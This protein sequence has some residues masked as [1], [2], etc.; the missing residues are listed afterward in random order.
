MTEE[1]NEEYDSITQ[2]DVDALVSQAN[3]AEAKNVELNNALINLTHEKKDGNFLHHQISTD[4]LLNRLENFYAGNYQGRDE[5]GNVCW[6]AP[7]DKDLVTFN[8][9]GVNSLME[10]ISKYIDRNTIL[11]DYSEQ[12]I[13]EIMGD[14][15]DE[16]IL[17][18]LCNYEKMGMD[19][20]HKKT[21]FRIIIAT[22]T[23][24]I[25]S[26]YRRAKN[27]RTLEE[28]NQSKVVSQYGEKPVM[29]NMVPIRR[30]NVVQR[31]LGMGG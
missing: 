16:L 25:E 20:Y 21:K 29:G 28:I 7:K 27:G 14:I 19:T 1:P 18:I 31:I 4:D 12:R 3:T 5:D 22:T 30:S 23:H 10:I 26:T 8:Q 11:S 6:K 24:I 9:Y 13:Y 17:L 2:D 15:G